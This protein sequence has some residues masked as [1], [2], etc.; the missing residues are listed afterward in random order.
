MAFGLSISFCERRLIPRHQRF[1]QP[2]ILQPIPKA[3]VVVEYI[4]AASW[5]LRFGGISQPVVACPYALGR[6]HIGLSDT[7]NKI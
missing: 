3:E 4:M 7:W 5:A 2:N 6:L 1:S